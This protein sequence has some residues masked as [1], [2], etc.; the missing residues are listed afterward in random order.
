MLVGVTPIDLILG[1]SRSKSPVLFSRRSPTKEQEEKGRL[2]D[3]RKIQKL[4]AKPAESTTSAPVINTEYIHALRASGA[5]GF[6]DFLDA[7]GSDGASSAWNEWS[8][9]PQLPS[10]SMPGKAYGF[11]HFVDRRET[12]SPL[13]EPS[14]DDTQEAEHST[15]ENDRERAL[16]DTAK[17]S[18]AAETKLL[19]RS[20]S[21]TSLPQKTVADP[22]RL[23]ELLRSTGAKG[24]FLT[25]SCTRCASALPFL[26]MDSPC[27]LRC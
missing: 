8:S 4:R 24:E 26:C 2:L 23:T 3:P 16:S 11:M 13:E 25:P 12:L 5:R 7:K 6:M 14:A 18:A 22:Q 27:Y 19:K 21:G 1:P 10:S 9:V 15:L 17:E 20:S